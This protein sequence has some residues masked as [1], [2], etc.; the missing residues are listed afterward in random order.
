MDRIVKDKWSPEEIAGYIKK[1]NIKFVIQ[2]SFQEI[3][4][5]IERKQIKVTAMDLTHKMKLKKKEK[6]ESR[7][8]KMP[9]HKEKSIHLRP[10]KIDKQEEFGH[11]E[12]DCV[13]G[14]KSKT[15]YLTILERITKKY[16]VIPMKEHTNECV[17]NAIDILEAK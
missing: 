8:N 5:W 3:Y 7:T 6:K 11:W 2:P 4:Y 10:E 13:E 17:G 1:H 15:T 16:I 12:L 9:K 14:K